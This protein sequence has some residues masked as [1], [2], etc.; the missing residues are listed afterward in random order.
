MHEEF[1]VAFLAGLRLTEPEHISFG[2]PAAMLHAAVFFV[3][4]RVSVA[5]ERSFHILDEGINVDDVAV[6]P[7]HVFFLSVPVGEPMLLLGL[8]RA[9]EVLLALF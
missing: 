3:D 4:N 8:E 9:D 7:S 5:V 1:V 2:H 6:G